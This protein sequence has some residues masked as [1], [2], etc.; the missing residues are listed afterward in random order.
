[1]NIGQI[2]TIVDQA[3]NTLPAIVV[4][5]SSARVPADERTGAAAHVQAC[6][7][8]RAFTKAAGEL[9]YI[10]NVPVYDTLAEATADGAGKFSAYTIY[11]SP[12]NESADLSIPDVAAEPV[13][14]APAVVAEPVTFSEE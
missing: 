11:A 7:S 3:G 1:M 8:V 9:P 12:D 13:A 14:P 4:G 2:V 10:S 5:K 6:A